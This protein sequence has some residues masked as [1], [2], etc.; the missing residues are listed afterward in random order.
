VPEPDVSPPPLRGIRVLECSRH[1]A[2]P[3][4]AMTLG[5]LG[6]DVIKLERPGIGDDARGWLPIVDGESCYFM[7]VNANKRSI[8]LDLADPAAA[9]VM[10]R[11]VETS[12]V[13]IE[14][15]RPGGLARMGY[16]D[17]LLAAWNRR[18]VHCAISAFGL[19]GPGRDRPGMDLLIQASGGLM[20]ITGEEGRPPVRVGISV[21]DLIAGANA[22]H[23]IL[24]ALLD[25]ERT[26]RGQRIDVALQDSLLAWLSYHVTT[27]LMTG[28]EPARMGAEH[29]S[30]AP[31]GAFATADGHLVIA[32]GTDD[33]W[34]DLA[35]A[36]GVPELIHDPRFARNPER[37][38]SRDSL[39]AIIEA[40]L[41]TAGAAEWADRLTAAG[42]PCS[43]V[44]TLGQ[45]L[46][47]PAVVERGRIERLDREDGSGVPVAAFP[48]EMSR[49]SH[50][51]RRPPPRLGEHTDE[52]LAE[53][54]IARDGPGS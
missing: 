1:L 32:V 2:G 49:S 6:A 10:R 7:S 29:A 44:R 18:L 21:V 39:R 42:V 53:L 31:Y 47:D 50:A 37:C 17:D 51:T 54:G 4:A 23:G 52:I 15:F 22:V 33:L 43:P 26:G 9:P 45:A 19:D 14:N 16:P 12:D 11:L 25:R 46:A 24:A 36:L 27:Y 5:D 34:A 40:R 3:Y 30:L 8:Q 13:L 20:A 28:R 41:A 48:V 38:A 35:A